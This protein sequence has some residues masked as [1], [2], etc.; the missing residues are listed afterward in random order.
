MTNNL[1]KRIKEVGVAQALKEL[2]QV[3]NGIEDEP[4]DRFV[5]SCGNKAYLFGAETNYKR[6][7]IESLFGFELSQEY[8]D[9]LKEL[10]KPYLK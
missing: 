1:L 3:P 9:Y 7:E 6:G 10:L 5:R 8:I 2:D 4:I